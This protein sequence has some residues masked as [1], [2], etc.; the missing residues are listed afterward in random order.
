MEVDHSWAEILGKSLNDAID[1]Y[2]ELVYIIE[3]K[4]EISIKYDG[5]YHV[6]LHAVGKEKCSSSP[7]LLN[8]LRKVSGRNTQ[9]D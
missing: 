6:R 9:G 7:L 8:A 4:G 2:R 3:N 5:A 1:I